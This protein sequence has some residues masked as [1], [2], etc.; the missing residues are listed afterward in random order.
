MGGHRGVSRRSAPP[1][2]R[3]ARGEHR[4]GHARHHVARRRERVGRDA[5][6]ARDRRSGQQRRRRARPRREPRRGRLRRV[7]EDA[8]HERI[9]ATHPG[10]ASASCARWCR[11]RWRRWWHCIGRVHGAPRLGRERRCQEAGG[12]RWPVFFQ[13]PSTVSSSLRRHRKRQ[14]L[15]T[16]DE[17]HR[18]AAC[19][20]D[21]YRLSRRIARG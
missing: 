20:S 9:A 4:G 3:G 12:I 1:G 13:P 17:A 11:G 14:G 5:R 16:E 21:L 15:R 19:L 8:R 6:G 7:A 2:L 18:T 10:A